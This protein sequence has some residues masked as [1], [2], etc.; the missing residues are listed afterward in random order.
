MTAFRNTTEMTEEGSNSN[1]R[2]PTVVPVCQVGSSM[3][4]YGSCDGT[5][6]KDYILPTRYCM[7][8]GNGTYGN[9][10][11]GHE[12]VIFPRELFRK[13]LTPSDVGK[14]NRLVIPKKYA[15][16]YLPPILRPEKTTGGEGDGSEGMMLEFK[17]RH[18]RV[19]EFRYCYWKSSHSFVF[20]KGWNKFVKANELTTDDTVLFYRCE[21]YCAAGEDRLKANIAIK[22]YYFMIDVK[23]T[24]QEDG[25]GVFRE[26]PE[27]AVEIGPVAEGGGGRDGNKDVKNGF[28]LFGVHIAPINI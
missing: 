19:W 2:T 22:D 25:D 16:Q 10:G 26:V 1:R 4:R 11:D 7:I 6:F 18:G 3:Y 28:K 15:V 14:L 23:R 24:C 12:G 27:T 8:F 5:K 20:T 21:E 13:E 9:A 17:D